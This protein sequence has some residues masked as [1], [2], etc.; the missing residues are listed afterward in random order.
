MDSLEA[1]GFDSKIAASKWTKRVEPMLATFEQLYGHRD[2]PRDFVVPSIAPWA[3][4]AWGVQ[5]GKLERRAP[6]Q[7]A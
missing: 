7:K 4:K 5:L 3:A 6:P 2:V 1:I